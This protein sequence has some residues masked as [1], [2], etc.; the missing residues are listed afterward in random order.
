M[1][2]TYILSTTR[3]YHA[4]RCVAVLNTWARDLDPDDK[5]FFSTDLSIGPM[6]RRYSSSC[7]KDSQTE[8]L[9][10]A[11]GDVRYW[12][13]DWVFFSCEDVAIDAK[14][15]KGLVAGLDP[16]EPKAYGHTINAYMHRPDFRY[17]SGGA[18]VLMSKRTLQKFPKSML[19]FV[20]SES[21][22]TGIQDVDF[23]SVMEASGIELVD[24]PFFYDQ[25]ITDARAQDA[26]VIH[27]VP[28]DKMRMVVELMKGPVY[29]PEC[30]TA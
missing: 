4:D 18:G 29:E 23:S 1:S 7:T 27:H 24:S 6:F 25:M 14:A 10:R 19:E 2:I 15:M 28:P 22:L 3:A 21:A 26:I 17:L 16:M 8:K 20:D 13:T 12:A 30:Q 5:F 9:V 11:L